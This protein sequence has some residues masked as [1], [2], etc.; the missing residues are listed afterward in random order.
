[1][2]NV[3]RIYFCNMQMK[4]TNLLND[5]AT[6]LLYKTIGGDGIDGAEF[7]AEINYLNENF[8]DTNTAE[9]SDSSTPII[10]APLKH[11]LQLNVLFTLT[12]PF[13]SV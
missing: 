2:Y 11:L 3:F 6:I 4:F 5:T 1:M 8:A 7:A 12:K 9:L 10:N 13:M